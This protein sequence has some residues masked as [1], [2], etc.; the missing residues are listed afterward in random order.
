MQA[1]SKSHSL[2]SISLNSVP[3][4]EESTRSII[5]HLRVLYFNNTLKLLDL[6]RNNLSEL[7]TDDLCDLIVKNSCL[8]DLNLSRNCFDDV[9]D[10]LVSL[11]Q[12]KTLTSLNLSSNDLTDV[13][14][15][16]IT[17]FLDQNQSP[18]LI[19]LSNNR[20]MNLDDKIIDTWKK[21]TDTSPTKLILWEPKLTE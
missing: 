17:F 8:T 7:H 9:E 10:I 18:K 20:F 3:L 2:T 21:Y 16:T 1:L 11:L 5:N 15:N 19:N 14:F 4:N 6:S 12:N 13:C